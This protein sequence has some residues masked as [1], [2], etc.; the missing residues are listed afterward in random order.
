MDPHRS[1]ARRR[2]TA[3]V[4]AVVTA[5][6]SIVAVTT[7][8]VAVAPG[9]SAL[10]NQLGRTPQMGWNSWNIHRCSIDEN[11]IK[12]AADSIVDKGLKAVGYQYVNID[13]CWQAST[14][15]ADGA[16]QPDPVRF[17]SGIKA[18]ADYVHG[19]GLK[20]GIYATPGSRTCAN[21][22]DNYPGQL[23]SLGHETQ[24]AK[25]FAAW[26]VDYLKYDWCK[27]NEDGV[28]AQ[29]AF[30]TMGS[31]LKATGLLI[32]YS[33]HR[34]PQQP[35]DPWRP[36][37]ANSWRTTSDISDNWASMI[38][39]AHSNQPLAPSPGPAPG[40]TPTCWKSATAA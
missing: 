21:I 23:G 39:K 33:I 37:V 17:P 31:A 29:Q 35:V 4:S 34:E 16:L 7:L 27:A 13:D 22:W 9:A 6:A 5:A 11:K 28:D 18:L 14:R 3:T 25:A 15:D 36:A 38:G 8:Q 1:P 19:K 24:D 20:L 32:F 10:D 26:G 40:T 2:I 30:T 12:A